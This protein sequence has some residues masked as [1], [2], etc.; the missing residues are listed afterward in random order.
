MHDGET[1]AFGTDLE[2][3]SLLNVDLA[4][5]KMSGIDVIRHVRANGLST[6]IRILTAKDALRSRVE[7]LDAG[8]DDYPTKPLEVE[9]PDARL[10]ALLRRSNTTLKSE[11]RFG[12]LSLDQNS[13]LV[14][15]NGSDL[16]LSRREHALL[17]TLLPACNGTGAL[18]LLGGAAPHPVAPPSL[19][20]S[21][22]A[23]SS[24][25]SASSFFSFRI[26]FLQRL[27]PFD[28][29]TPPNR[30]TWLRVV[31]RGG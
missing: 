18:Q 14:T 13:R 22:A 23:S 16:H 25:C 2:N 5:P 7:G 9:E 21:N 27:Q 11:V 31:Q 24:I 29:Q 1:A 10:R 15:I 4:L 17:E 12:T 28:P 19:N 6:P 26:Y 3:Y 30:R 8:A 20:G